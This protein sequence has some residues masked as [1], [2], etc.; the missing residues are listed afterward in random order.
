MKKKTKVYVGTNVPRGPVTIAMLP[1]G[2]RE[3]AL[4]KRLSHDPRGLRRMLNRLARE[5]EVRVC[6]EASGV[7]YVLERKIQSWGHACEIVAQSL[8]PR[9]PGSVESTT[10]GTPWNSRGSTGRQSW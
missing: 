9:R 10:E 2:A 8:I 7:G 4:V 6:F 5:H 1:E 3:P